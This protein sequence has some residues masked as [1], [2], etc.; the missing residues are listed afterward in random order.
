[1]EVGKKYYFMVHAYHHF[2]GEV[3]EVHGPNRCIINN[4]IRVQSSNKD[5]TRFFKEGIKGKD[6]NYTIWPDGTRISGDFVCVPWNHPI[7]RD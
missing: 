6:T 1:M 3:V 5:W 4:V 2:I 7:P